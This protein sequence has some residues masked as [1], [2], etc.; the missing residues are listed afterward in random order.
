M[1]FTCHLISYGLVTYLEKIFI[2]KE[3]NIAYNADV[4][5]LFCKSKAVVLSNAATAKL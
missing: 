3:P 1:Y 4:C 5:A 2:P